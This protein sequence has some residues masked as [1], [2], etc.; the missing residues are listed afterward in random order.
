MPIMEAMNLASIAEGEVWNFFFTAA[1]L[2]IRGGTGSPI[3]PL[4]FVPTRTVGS[5]DHLRSD[6][7]RPSSVGRPGQDGRKAILDA[8]AAAFARRGYLATSIDAIADEL[9]A[10]K[11]RVYHY[12]RGKAEVFLDV[13]VSGMQDLIGEMGPLGHG[14]RTGAGGAPPPAWCAAMPRS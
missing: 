2:P 3:R 12:Y 10:T 13:V 1:P 14:T 6:Q 5:H 8:A 9:G 4:A 11:G 7:S